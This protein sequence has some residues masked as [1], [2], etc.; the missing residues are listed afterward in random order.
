[1]SLPETLSLEHASTLKVM[2]F[3]AQ[4]SEKSA[5]LPFYLEHDNTPRYILYA[6]VPQHEGEHGLILPYQIARGTIRAQ[7]REGERLFWIDKGRRCAGAQAE[8]VRDES[9]V[10]AAVR[11]AKEEL[12]L[13]AT[14]IETLYDCGRLPYQNPRGTVYSLFVFLARIQGPSVLDFPDP[15]ACA[16]RLNGATLAEAQELSKIPPEESSFDNRPFKASYLTLLEALHETVLT[17]CRP[18]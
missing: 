14:G 17:Y 2:R 15:Y 3:N 9:P 13:P 11:E 8:W 6:P 12:G 10:E 16:A 4:K 5:I 1:M 7:Y 18:L